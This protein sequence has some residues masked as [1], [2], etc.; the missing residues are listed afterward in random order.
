[1]KQQQNFLRQLQVFGF[2]S[3]E[4]FI[5]ASLITEDPILLIGRAGTGK[6]FLLN[7]ISEA[8]G[9][10]HRHYNASLIS[11][12]DLIGFPYPDEGHGSVRFLP[13]PATIWNAE[14]VLMDEL[15]RCKPETQNKFFSIIH[16]RKIQGI[17][18]R[19]LR[20]R[21]AAMNPFQFS[22]EDADEQYAGSG[23]LDP[24]LADR[25]ALILDVPDWMDISNADQELII[26]P[27]GEDAISDDHG[28]LREWLE[29]G[30]KEFLIRI[31]S[32]DPEIVLYTRLVTGL[33]NRAGLRISPRRARLICRNII[34]CRVAAEISG[35]PADAKEKKSLL[36]ATLRWSLP[37]RAYR[38][39]IPEH[40]VDAAHAEAIKMILDCTPNER[41]LS[42][43]QLE[44]SLTKKLDLLLNSPIHNDLRSIALMQLLQAETPIRKTA[45]AFAAYPL[46]NESGLF[47]EESFQ[48]LTR[49]ANKILVFEGTMVWRENMGSRNNTHPV[50]YE[51][52]NVLKDLSEQPE[53]RDR[54]KHFF[55]YLL[56]CNE[57]IRD[58]HIAEGELNDLFVWIQKQKG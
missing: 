31:E 44:D 26:H 54:A 20:Y 33:L 2:E 13:T 9:L 12:D 21:W 28:A 39:Q 45:F 55:L 7:S 16:E 46:L 34:A 1:M 49:L 24:A 53:R 32:P 11:F 48:E 47:N 27:K 36:K 43:F 29:K 50:W 17:P 42:E 14:S 52:Q 22:G 4:T 37:Q 30:K 58:P 8:L 35:I 57:N 6:T 56:S 3:L 15:S 19:Q 18:L 40:A 41:W 10:E 5:L 25:F 38:E 51:C 23:P